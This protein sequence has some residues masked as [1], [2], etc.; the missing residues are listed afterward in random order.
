MSSILAEADL[1][2]AVD[3]YPALADLTSDSLRRT[4]PHHG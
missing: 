4:C 1:I 3:G 2:M